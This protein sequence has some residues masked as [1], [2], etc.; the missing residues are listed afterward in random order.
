MKERILIKMKMIFVHL[1]ESI[2]FSRVSINIQK[3]QR[4]NEQSTIY[5]GKKKLQ[6]I[7]F[8]KHKIIHSIQSQ[9][10]KRKSMAWTMNNKTIERKIYSDL[11]LSNSIFWKSDIFDNY[12]LFAI[13]L[14]C[15]FVCFSCSVISSKMQ[16]HAIR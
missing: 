10:L 5:G 16:T 3:F 7:S 9:N 8:C 13:T 4:L 14:L 11:L 6:T 15:V 1:C 12:L 2:F